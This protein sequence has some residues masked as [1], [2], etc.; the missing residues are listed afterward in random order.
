MTA[1]T[2]PALSFWSDTEEL[3]SVSCLQEVPN[4]MTFAFRSPS[5]ALFTYE[6]GQFL[7]SELPLPQGIGHRTSAI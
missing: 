2:R 7:T 3:E 6:P 5:G 1:A 4:V